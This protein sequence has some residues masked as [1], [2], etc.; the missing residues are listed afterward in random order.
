MGL[1]ESYLMW[2][3]SETSLASILWSLNLAKMTTRIKI[4]SK[5]I[6]F[7]AQ[8]DSLTS[9]QEM[10]CFVKLNVFVVSKTY[11]GESS[12]LASFLSMLPFPL[13]EVEVVWPGF[14]LDVPW[15]L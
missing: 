1:K 5:Y 14:F 6:Q 9:F 12:F 11:E 7:T 3:W 2:F 15:T 10:H 13:T 4:D 8:G